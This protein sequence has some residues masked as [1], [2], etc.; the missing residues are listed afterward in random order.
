MVFQ[1]KLGCW[2]QRKEN[3]R[4]TRRLFADL[5]V[6]I[7]KTQ[8]PC[9]CIQNTPAKCFSDGDSP[10]RPGFC[11]TLPQVQAKFVPAQGWLQSPPT[12]KPRRQATAT[13]RPLAALHGGVGA[14]C[15]PS[16]GKEEHGFGFGFLLKTRCFRNKVGMAG[17][18]VDFISDTGSLF[19]ASQPSECLNTQAL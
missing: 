8:P 5:L 14:R 9:W 12:A 18:L 3:G 16:E 11:S 1:G 10:S 4:W 15:S 7:S 13:F 6:V 17:N 19:I 2:Y